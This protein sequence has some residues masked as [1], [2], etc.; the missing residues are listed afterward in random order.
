[1]MKKTIQSSVSL[2]LAF[3]FVLCLASC[4]NR[5]DATGLWENATYKKD[6][7]LGKGSKTF[8]LEVTVEEQTVTFTVNT[9]AKTV[10]AALLELELIDGDEGDFGLYIKKVNGMTADYDTDKSYWAFYIN[11]EYAM[12]GVDGTDIEEGVTYRLAREQ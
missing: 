3:L 1:M 6:T 2:L 11:G 9:D 12:T 5:V 4:G 10:G 8:T 7:E